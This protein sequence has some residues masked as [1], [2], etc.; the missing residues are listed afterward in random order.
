L[1][2]MSISST[3]IDSAPPGAA[4]LRGRGHTCDAESTARR[5][6]CEASR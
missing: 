4:A 6:I 3:S 2:I 1:A 5:Y